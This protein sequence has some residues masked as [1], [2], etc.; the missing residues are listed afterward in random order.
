M[1]CV[2]NPAD[3][4][5]QTVVRIQTVYA[6]ADQTSPPTLINNWTSAMEY[7]TYYLERGRRLC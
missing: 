2:N 1:S 3:F 4:A 7:I 5:E 6:L